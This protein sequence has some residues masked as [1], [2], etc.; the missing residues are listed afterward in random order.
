MK[1]DQLSD[2]LNG[3][4]ETTNPE[5]ANSFTTA[6]IGYPLGALFGFIFESNTRTKLAKEKDVTATAY[7]IDELKTFFQEGKLDKYLKGFSKETITQMTK[8][9]KE[10]ADSMRRYIH[11]PSNHELYEIAGYLQ[12]MSEEEQKEAMNMIKGKSA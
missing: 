7:L 11:K 12:R 3:L 10:L 6:A 1:L 4:R 5:I 8:K 9:H 2:G